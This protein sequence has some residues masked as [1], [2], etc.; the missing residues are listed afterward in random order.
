MIDVVSRPQLHHGGL[1]ATVD[2][3]VVDSSVR[4]IGIATCL[5]DLAVKRATERGARLIEVTSG[6]ARDDA[7]RFYQ[8]Q[9]FEKNGV[10]LVRATARA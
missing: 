10:R 7:H 6:T 9:H 4:G 5:M 1:V 3:L 8:R 2:S